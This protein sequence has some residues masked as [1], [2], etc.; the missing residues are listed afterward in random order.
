MHLSVISLHYTTIWQGVIIDNWPYSNTPLLVRG[1]LST[2]SR[3]EISVNFDENMWKYRE[4]KSDDYIQTRLRWL[5]RTFLNYLRNTIHAAL[6]HNATMDISAD[7]LP[8]LMDSDDA[9][10]HD[11]AEQ[12][13][14]VSWRHSEQAIVV[15]AT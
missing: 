15:N 14:L 5:S 9:L 12:N 4:G 7:N 2:E 8:D 10:Y 13:L 1:D 11:I 3:T 6:Q